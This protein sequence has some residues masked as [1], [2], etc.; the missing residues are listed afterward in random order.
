MP[1][2]RILTDIPGPRSR[3]LAARAPSAVAR[4]VAP[5]DD[6]FGARAEGAVIEDVDGNR[7]L[8]FTGGVGCLAAGHAHP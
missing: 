4:A 8:D 7:Y 3:E 1:S 5:G 2:I 6:I